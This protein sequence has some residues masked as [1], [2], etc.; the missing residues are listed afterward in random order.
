MAWFGLCGYFFFSS[1]FSL[2]LHPSSSFF[3]GVILGI[4]LFELRFWSV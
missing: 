2:L 1:F 4:S 3:T